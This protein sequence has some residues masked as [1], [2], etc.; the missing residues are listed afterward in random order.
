M[1]LPIA[2]ARTESLY[3]SRA[4]SSKIEEGGGRSLKT[5]QFVGFIKIAYSFYVVI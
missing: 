3:Q 5:L 1:S 4:P 2:L